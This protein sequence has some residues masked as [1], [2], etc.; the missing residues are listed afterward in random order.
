MKAKKKKEDVS[1][2]VAQVR[3]RSGQIVPFRKEKI[4]LAVAKAFAATGEGS[5]KDAH[6]VADRVARLLQKDAMP[7]SVPKIEDI[8]DLAERVLMVL[9]FEETAKAYIL[10]RE[11]HRRLRD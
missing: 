5:K 9:D 6:I 2:V 11:Q 7:G 3:K 8:Q 10:Y 4:A 1:I